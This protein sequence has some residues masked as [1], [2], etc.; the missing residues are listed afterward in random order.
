MTSAITDFINKYLPFLSNMSPTMQYAII[1]GAI[2]LLV[3][4]VVI[5]IIAVTVSKKKK[6]KKA[7]EAKAAE[8]A[9]ANEPVQDGS[10]PAYQP[11]G[12]NV[13]G[14]YAAQEPANAT[15]EP[16]AETPAYVSEEQPQ[17]AQEPAEEEEPQPAEEPAEEKQSVTAIR[18]VQP[19]QPVVKAVNKSSTSSN[20]NTTKKVI[21]V[22]P[23]KT[24]DKSASKVY[25]ISKRKDDGRWQ[26]KAEG[27][28]KAIKLFLTQKEAIDYCK[29]LAGNQEA[30]IMIH[31]EDGSF[32]K[33]TY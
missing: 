29:T 23:A 14:A 4:I 8:S 22:V 17:S 33:L 18:K 19:K 9:K 16:V 30:R 28:A 7:A 1:G 24:S 13:E 5:I 10:A 3:L 26:I 31:K 12:D 25:H 20:S 15:A 2:G 27:G 32:R 6:K 11:A 21:K